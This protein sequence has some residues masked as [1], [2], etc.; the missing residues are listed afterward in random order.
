MTTSEVAR[1]LRVHR[2]TVDRERQAGRLACVRIGRRVFHT[3]EQVK[4]YVNG[5]QRTEGRAGVL[6]I[7]L[8]L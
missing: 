8:G 3:E 4:V 2:N 5:Q 6:Q 7:D 1:V